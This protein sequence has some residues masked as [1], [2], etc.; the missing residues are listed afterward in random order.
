LVGRDV[1]QKR[2]DSDASRP[3]P[4]P[5]QAKPPIVG[6]GAS[7]G[8]IKAL[9]EF[10]DATPDDTGAAFIVIVHLDPESRSELPG[11]LATRTKMPVTQVHAKTNLEKDHIYV[12]PPDR[13]LSLSDHEVSAV[14]FDVPRG[15]R[16]PIDLFFRSL[17]QQHGD[18]FAIILT[19]AGSDGA[20]GVKAIKEAGGIVLVQDPNEAEYPSMP[21]SAIA[22]EV[23]DFVLPTREMG[24]RLAE[25]I[26]NRGQVYETLQDDEEEY[27]RRI[28]SH[29]RVR[30]GHD[31]SHYKR[32]T[33]LRRIVRRTQVTRT[34]SLAA[35]YTFLRE[36]ADEAQALLADLLISVTTFFRDPKAFEILAK[37][38]IPKLFEGKDADSVVRVWIPGCATGEEAYTI[39]MLI[40]EEGARTE[41]RPEIQIFGS[42]MDAGAL[43]IAREGRYPEAIATDLSEE[44]LRRFF[45]REGDHFRVKRELRDVVLFAQHS[46]L[47]DPP[48]SKLDLVSCRNLLIYLNRELQSQVLNTVHYALNPDGFLMLGSSESAEHPHNLFRAVDRDMRIYQSIAGTGDRFTGLPHLIRVPGGGDYGV[49]PR[50]RA[51]AAAPSDALAH[52]QALE[53]IAPPSI[54]V[55][56]AHRAVHLSES[57]GRYLQPSGGPLTGDVS[58]LVRQEL[59]FDLRAAL[60][61]SFERGETTL[62]API[63]VKF[64][65]VAHRMYFQVRPIPGA[66]GDG[67]PRHALVVFIEGEA[68]EPAL[69]DAT[70]APEEGRAAHETIRRLEQE[71]QLSESRLRTTRE[72]SEATN[73]EL[74]AANEELQSINEEYRSTS[75][76]LETSKEE[77]QSINEELQTVNSELKLKLESISRAHSDLQNLMAATD[78]GTLFLDTA[79]RIKR[80]TPKLN[81]IFNITVSDEGRPITDFTHR[82]E[83]ERL[84][85][86]ARKVL[87]DLTPIE[88]E[89]PGRKGGWYLVRLR[90][91][92]TVDDK[93]D[94]VVATFVDIS[95]RRH[96]EDALKKSDALLR[97]ESRLIAV[98]RTPMFSWELDGGIVDWNRGCEELY[99]YTKAEAVG[100]TKKELL[101][102]TV[103]GSSF[104]RLKQELEKAG[105]WSGEIQ[106]VTKDGRTLSVEGQLDLSVVE[107]RQLVFESTRDITERKAWDRQQQLLLGEL[108]HRIKNTLAVV[109]SIAGQT[110]R[111]SP[112]NKEFVDRFNGRIDALARAH[113]LLLD[114]HWSGTDIGLIVRG[115]LEPYTAGDAKRIRI[116]GPQVMMRAD[117]AIPFGLMLHELATNA[118]KYGSLSNSKGYVELNWNSAVR[119]RKRILTVVWQEH[120]G[121]A[122]KEPKVNGLGS[123]LI[124]KGLPGAKVRHDYRKEG[125]VCTVEIP[126][127][128][129]QSGD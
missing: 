24:P 16:S 20:V 14:P 51:R 18:G 35:Y 26:R 41:T 4:E 96:T 81:E 126:L 80:F 23:A 58:D 6:I 5:V 74:R 8:G 54:L 33:V 30:T 121:P 104:E 15:Q 90:P 3:A 111:N 100:K 101:K 28:L 46:I 9:Q 84:A 48:F 110:L 97:Q 39:A 27:L 36:N 2:E 65:G 12:I 73:E 125:V 72:E 115:Q 108:A 83:Y 21:R 114:S 61:R 79:L 99:G 60:H 49:T 123:R 13:S 31:F 119:N 91:Y 87:R 102:T 122:V 52:R 29:V 82:L 64:N 107:G 11:I 75:E 69:A 37:R 40:L 94:G 128:S 17:A 113:G 117:Q 62:S 116:G 95:E 127:S 43:S 92:R 34:D 78:F 105:T 89:V 68:V 129:D 93:I 120:K 32:S 59:R 50:D 7:A 86:D 44:R 76:E 112:S 67:H 118:A 53:R 1:N 55:D 66:Q 77:L 98:S 22:T 63:P 71:L 88:R 109:Q 25:L 10:F 106:H 38:V 103:P 124:A 42:D 70:P 19:G 47:K 45:S 85:D 56:E 57:A